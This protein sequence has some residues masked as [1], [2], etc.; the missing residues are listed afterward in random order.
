MTV[1]TKVLTDPQGRIVGFFVFMK[2]GNKS[3]VRSFSACIAVEK[4][5]ALMW[6]MENQFLLYQECEG[7]LQ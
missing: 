6:A 1:E 2:A 7:V 5:I 3:Q 4:L